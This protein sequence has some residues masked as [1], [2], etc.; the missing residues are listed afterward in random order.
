MPPL[1]RPRRPQRP[2][3]RTALSRGR[4][5]PPAANPPSPTASVGAHPRLPT[6]T[7]TTMAAAPVAAGAS[8]PLDKT[9]E[10]ALPHGRA[11]AIAIRNSR[12]NPMGIVIFSKYGLPT[13]IRSPVVAS[14]SS[15]NTVPSNTT[16]ANAPNSRLLPRKAPVRDTGEAIDPSLRRSSPRQAIRPTLTAATRAKKPS[17]SGPMPDSVNE[18]TDSRTPERVTNVPRMVKAKVEHSSERFQTRSIP[19]RSWTITE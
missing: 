19:C 9:P 10:S 13:E 3:D 15:G 7:A 1:D 6:A 8:S 4:S 2:P 11:G 18:C 14:T 12:A 17:S 16:K 5:A